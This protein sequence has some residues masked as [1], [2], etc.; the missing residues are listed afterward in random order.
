[1]PTLDFY[2][3]L[4]GPEEFP[5]FYIRGYTEALALVPGVRVIPNESYLE[6]IPEEHQH[7]FAIMNYPCYY[8]PTKL[9]RQHFGYVLKSAGQKQTV[10]FSTWLPVFNLDAL[11]ADAPLVFATEGI[12]VAYVFL[13]QGLPTM[14]MLGSMLT[15]ET[16]DALAAHHKALC[17][18]PDNDATGRAKAREFLHKARRHGVNCTVYVPQGHKDFGDWFDLQGTPAHERVRE[19]F[20]ACLR[21]ASVLQRGR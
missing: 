12:K 20:R 17:V 9:G 7:R 14:A 11:T 19:N 8:A 21:R 3:S 5:G 13:S 6:T 1:M 15:A 4:P 18:I 2:L 16:F 10:H